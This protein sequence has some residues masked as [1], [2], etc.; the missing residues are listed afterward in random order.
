MAMTVKQTLSPDERR[1]LHDLAAQFLRSEKIEAIERLGQ[2]NVHDTYRVRLGG[3]WPRSLVLQRLN[4]SI[5]PSPLDVIAN[6]QRCCD[7]LEERLRSSPPQALAD[8]R[9]EVPALL[10]TRDGSL[11]VEAEGS[12]WRAHA[13]HRR[14]PCRADRG[15]GCTPRP[16][17]WGSAW[18]CFTT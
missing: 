8:Q 12:L 14:Q 18:G 10:C 9:W 2:G 5:Y 1:A 11:L 16:G 15:G 4:T 17:S 13:I 7:H 3:E 6:M